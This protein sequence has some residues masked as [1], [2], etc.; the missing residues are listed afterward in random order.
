MDVGCN[1]ILQFSVGHALP[2]ALPIQESP[3]HPNPTARPL[4]RLPPTIVSDDVTLKVGNACPSRRSRMRRRGARSRTPC[5][6]TRHYPHIEGCE[7]GCYA[8]KDVGAC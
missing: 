5:L 1:L 6:R 8:C 3:I 2:D 7:K 4:L